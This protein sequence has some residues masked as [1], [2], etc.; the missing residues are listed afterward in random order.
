MMGSLAVMGLHRCDS[1]LMRPGTVLESIVMQ[2]ADKPKEMH[3]RIDGDLARRIEKFRHSL[4][5]VPTA[6]AA[7]QCLIQRGLDSIDGAR[8]PPSGDAV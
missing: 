1:D 6:S 5:V 3:L 7:A 2:L 4:L 8:S